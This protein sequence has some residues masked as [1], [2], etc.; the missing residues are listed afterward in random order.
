MSS[1]SKTFRFDFSAVRYS[2]SRCPC[3]YKSRCN[4]QRGAE[5]W[6]VATTG[7][8]KFHVSEARGQNYHGDPG[9]LVDLNLT[10]P[11][12]TLKRISTCLE[13]VQVD[14]CPGE[15][16]FTADRSENLPWT[17]PWTACPGKTVVVTRFCEQ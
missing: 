3:R 8:F 4:S 1:G 6:V 10:F 14:P 13:I 15:F 11:I 17:V 16:F 9:A 7:P 12:Q 5:P 2:K